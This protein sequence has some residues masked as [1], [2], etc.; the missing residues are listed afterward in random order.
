MEAVRREEGIPLH[1]DVVQFISREEGIPLHPDV[2]QFIRD[3]CAE[4]SVRCM[5]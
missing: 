3:T 4:L 2:V 1:P 5:F